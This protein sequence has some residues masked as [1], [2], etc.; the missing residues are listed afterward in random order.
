MIRER[1]SQRRPT[2]AIASMRLTPLMALLPIAASVADATASASTDRTNTAK[3]VH[4]SSTDSVNAVKTTL[5]LVLGR[6]VSAYS[7]SPGK[8]RTCIIPTMPTRVK[9]A[10]MKRICAC[11]WVMEDS[12]GISL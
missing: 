4:G 2:D 5:T 6:C 12:E 3:A 11:T 10:E 8:S 9:I 7:S 1:P